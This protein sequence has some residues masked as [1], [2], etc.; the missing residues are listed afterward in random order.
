MKDDEA[1]RGKD[2]IDGVAKKK[3]P[4]KKKKNASEPDGGKT[5]LE[6]TAAPSRLDPVGEE[7]SEEV[8]RVPPESWV[9]ITSICDAAVTS[10]HVG[11]MIQSPNFRLFDAMSAIEI[12]DPKMDSGYNNSEDMTL[13]RAVETGVVTQTMSH[14]DFIG[15]W[16][17]LLM[18]FLM[19]LDGH[20][21]V[22]T[23]FSC[24]YLQDLEACVKPMPLFSAFVD[25]FLIACRKARLAVLK[26]GIFDDEDFV[27]NL[28]SVDLEAHVHSSDPTVVRARIKKECANL[29]RDPSP[30]GKAVASRLEFIGDYMLTLADLEG[31]KRNMEVIRERL[32]NCLRLVEVLS[33]T[34]KSASLDVLR[35]FDASSNR[36][37]LGP[38]PP[39]TVEP[40]TDSAVVFGMWRSH[41]HELLLCS[42]LGKKTLMQLLEG[43]ITHKE[44]PNVLPRSIAQLC[45][46]ESA[47]L[48]RLL[49]DSLESYL[50]PREALQ[51]CK[52]A[53]DS[54]LERSASLFA[55]LLKLSHVNRARRFRRLAHTFPDFNV[56]QHEAWQLDEDLKKT[57][58]ANLPHPRPSSLWIMEHCLQAMLEKLFLGFELDLYDQVELHMIYWYADYIY[59]LRIYNMNE[60][61]CAKEQLLGGASKRRPKGPPAAA[62]RGAGQRPRNPP[63][64]LLLMEATQCAVR[65]L[66]RLLAH[67][68][69]GGQL[70]APSMA[71]EGLAQRFVLRFR[72][73]EQFRLPH[74]PSFQDFVKN[75]ASLQEPVENRAVLEAAQIS[76]SE[77]AQLLEKLNAAREKDAV[78]PD[79]SLDDAK[80][81][82]RVVVANQLAIAK[83]LQS[84]ALPQQPKVTA[85]TTHH[86]H[87]V[88]VQVPHDKA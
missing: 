9:D 85:A 32:T 46:S 57:F 73:L 76:F 55:H 63:P 14:E 18:Y 38:G 86:P 72:S 88:S 60:L 74:L 62:A 69:R 2:D 53:A 79:V 70:N 52:K 36:K 77:S 11:E 17:R 23:I 44:E 87:L 24:L 1:H 10:M 58:G 71:L 37:L 81:L 67:C 7:G 4:K 80:A 61:C 56:L 45:V 64:A 49:V 19:W 16:D 12:M 27:P 6:Y 25:A 42:N 84:F 48:R 30:L 29:E 51:H 66:F 3:K 47:L 40:I 68:L 34:A 15:L 39:R 35:C 75:S 22:Q 59:G 28:C 82:K 41:L 8:W 33:E 5:Q 65:G 13:E 78:P 20:T 43:G 54:F 31:D 50:F 21:I 26:A 83:L